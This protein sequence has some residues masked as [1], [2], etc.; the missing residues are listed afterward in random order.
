MTIDWWTLGLQTV[1]VLILI[2]LL[3][4]F[5]WKPL[6][7]MIAERRAS[8]QQI[9][10][11]A[12]QKR[13][14]AEAALAAIE[15]TRAGF[16]KER[17]AILEAARK[18]AEREHA[19]RISQ[20]ETQATAL[21]EAAKAQIEHN[22]YAAEKTWTDRASKLAVEIATRLLEPLNGPTIETAFLDRLLHEISDLPEAARHGFGAEGTAIDATSA[23]PLTPEDQ[24]HIRASLAQA[25]QANPLISF[26]VD[27][28]LIA[29]LELHGPH[30]FVSNSWRADLDRILKEL[31]RDD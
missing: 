1:N 7:S 18:E 14:E 8:T 10:A 3:G 22:N 28:G 6:A 31:T 16:A 29:G 4:R 13:G 2:W 24:V 27:P 12:E 15:T 23:K 26:K 19:A 5:F 17:E 11:A 25:L 21:I 30:I 20:T 9:L